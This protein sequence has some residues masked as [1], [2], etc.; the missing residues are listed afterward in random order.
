MGHPDL[1]PILQPEQPLCLNTDLDEVYL[2]EP[3]LMD[4][5]NA[6]QLGQSY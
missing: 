1:D 6:G 4:L 3:E 2:P 5:D